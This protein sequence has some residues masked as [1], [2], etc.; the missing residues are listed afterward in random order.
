M[1]ASA[2]VMRK[3]I[4]VAFIALAAVFI[5]LFGRLF[6][7]QI[8]DGG[9]LRAKAAEQWY[10]DLPLKAARGKIFDCNGETLADSKDVF[11]L[12]A[13]PNAVKDKTAVATEI[14]EALDMEYQ[15]V[16]DKL[17]TN[18][19]EV[20]VKRKIDA[21][22][23]YELRKK[24]ISGLYYTLD[25]QRNY[26][27]GNSLAQILGFTNIDNAGQSGIESYY[28]KYLTG[29]DGFA[30]TSTDMAGR[31]LES[32]VTKYVPSI[33]G[34]NVT[35]SVD[36][37][38][39][40]FADSAVIAAATEF[41]AKSASMIVMD[42]NTGGILAMSKSPSFDLN[43]PP[44]NDLDLL[45]E[46]SR[47]TMIV[48]MYEPG[49]TFKIFTTAAALEAGVVGDNDTF[50][51]AGSRTVDGQ[52]IRC[53]RS[54]GHGSQHLA[55]GVKN[56]CNC[57][58]MDLALRL[59]TSRFYSALRNFG[60]GQKTG[61]DFTG[62][63]SGMMMKED[64]VKTVDLAR[65]GFGQAV[66]VT[67]LQLIT[68]VCSVINGG[69]L[70][71]PYLVASVDSYDGKNLAT[72]EPQPVR[73]TVS[74]A[75]SQKMRD[76]LVGVVANGGGSKAGVAGYSVGGKTGTAQKYAGGTIAQGK[77]ISSFIGFAPAENPKYA[78]LMI[79]D[80]PQ[81]YMYYGSLVAAPYAGN[82]FSKI[83]DY[84]ALPP[85]MLAEIEYAIMPDVIGK[86][87]VDAVK[88]LED[89]GLHAE[90]V[91]E[92]EKVTAQTPVPQTK[93]AKNDAVLVR[94]E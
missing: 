7:L 25:T 34:C 19:G 29:V 51:C 62:E 72:R 1:K 70:Y 90:L 79:V 64:N 3:R 75:T 65:I 71:K 16:F 78:V 85:S 92:G 91:G 15:T 46:L 84:T 18:V 28:D 66:A 93:I 36:S 42:V 56:S 11:T 14:A 24:N 61:V 94:A 74:E 38:I 53:W 8:I 31:E 58:F 55:E 52:R 9:W 80:E 86:P 63:S 45:N 54:I 21:Q 50:F 26:P 5:A 10:R 6:Y 88:E 83:F 17:N 27:F 81:G 68:G 23:A 39:Q 57:V 77:Y 59:G 2:S 89:A 67:P 47:N 4:L 73:R 60:M 48:D 76:Y 87:V 69:T 43:D 20:T 13:R 30:Y 41:L 32:S 44:R 82:V 22:S 35:L 37:N 33:P 40:S 12:Y 49:S